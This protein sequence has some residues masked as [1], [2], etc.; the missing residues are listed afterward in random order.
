MKIGGSVKFADKVF[1]P[2][3]TPHYDAYKG[4]VFQVVAYHDNFSHV[5]L[6]C[7]TDP[8]IVVNGYV[9][10]DEVQDL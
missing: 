7:A 5:E 2:P 8:Q 10:L 9:H 6:K 3:Y 4:H 1:A